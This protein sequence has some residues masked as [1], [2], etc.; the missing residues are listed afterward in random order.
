MHGVSF[1]PK[2]SNLFDPCAQDKWPLCAAE[3]FVSKTCHKNVIL[4]LHPTRS[5]LR[6]QTSAAPSTRLHMDI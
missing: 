1:K 3:Y 6:A 2:I 5:T 4:I